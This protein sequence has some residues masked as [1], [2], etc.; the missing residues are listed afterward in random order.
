MPIMY[1]VVLTSQG[2]IFLYELLSSSLEYQEERRV[3]KE[4]ELDFLVH[5]TGGGPD[6]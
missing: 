4:S 2:I 5:V 1:S 3:S 6:G